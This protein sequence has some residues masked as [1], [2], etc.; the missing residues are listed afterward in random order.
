MTI[1]QSTAIRTA[2][3]IAS[4]LAFVPLD[5]WGQN[6][7]PAP[8]APSAQP[9]PSAPKAQSASPAQNAPNASNTPNAQNPELVR[10]AYGSG[11]DGLPAVVGIER[12]FFHQENLVV[13]GLPTSS[14]QALATSLA[15]GSTDFAVVP[16]R[17]FIALAASNLPIKAVG[18]G[19]SG[20]QMELVGK[21]GSGAKSITDLKA[22]T[23]G[24]ASTSESLAILMRLLNAAK[25][26][27]ADVK[28]VLMSP[29]EVEVAFE[30]GTAD[31]IFES[32]HYTAP[33]IQAGKA[34]SI[35]KPEDVRKSIGVIDAM[36][37]ITTNALI[38]KNPALVEKVVRAW[39]KSLVYIQQ[40]PKDAAALLQIF[41]HR[42]G[43]KVD[44]PTVQTWV[45]MADYNR[46]EWSQPLVA[47][48]EYDAWGLQQAKVL[49]DAPKL[50][51]FI[52]NSFAEKAMQSIGLK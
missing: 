39:I 10:L 11:W 33:M 51:P 17:M 1:C 30:K 13:S 31:A 24:L 12:G 21:A 5:V 14:A 25:L 3:I 40:D 47:D 28:I 22:K 41:L 2:L 9:A 23:I 6:P 32:R 42:Q 46:Y 29:R 50:G 43:V 49:K 48:A 36:P 18:V 35:M 8:A 4:F 44:L 45:G 20:T 15:A 27:P 19:V 16:Q 37:L 38:Q 34:E 26:T 7:P 52:D